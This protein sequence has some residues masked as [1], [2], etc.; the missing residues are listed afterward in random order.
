[1]QYLAKLP[2]SPKSSIN[3]L[4]TQTQLRH[5]I[6][7]F[8]NFPKEDIIIPLTS[9]QNKGVNLLVVIPD[10]S[11]HSDKNMSIHRLMNT[12][13]NIGINVTSSVYDD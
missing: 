1:M 9:L 4:L 5:F 12:L 11:T 6:I 10:I 7:I 13:E 2:S 8:L 3:G